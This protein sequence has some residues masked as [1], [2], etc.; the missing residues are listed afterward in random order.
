MMTRCKGETTFNAAVNHAVERLAKQ[1]KH[2]GLALNCFQLGYDVRGILG[3]V[4][5]TCDGLRE[6]KAVGS[7]GGKPLDNFITHC[8][9]G[10]KHE[11]DRS[12]IIAQIEALRA[13]PRVE[14]T[15]HAL[16]RRTLRT[17]APRRTHLSCA[18]ACVHRS[19]GS[20]RH[21]PVC[22]TLRGRRRIT[23]R[24]DSPAVQ[25]AARAPPGRLRAAARARLHSLGAA[26]PCNT[27]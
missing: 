4:C 8:T 25:D 21:A 18:F 3:A 10:V 23:A 6:A 11:K 19:Q 27:W 16:R 2:G 24:D 15:R 5:F 26:G 12:N 20:S 1:T 9:K 17:L 7:G 22:R 13:D 14:L